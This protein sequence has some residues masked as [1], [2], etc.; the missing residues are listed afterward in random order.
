MA[1]HFTGK[2]NKLAAIANLPS[3]NLLLL[4]SSTILNSK[5]ITSINPVIFIYIQT[6]CSHCQKETESLLKNYSSLKN[7]K[8][9]FLTSMSLYDLKQFDTYYHLSS[10][11]NI[12]VGKDYEHSFAKV[13]M[14]KTVPFMAIYNNNKLVKIYKGDIDVQVILE[15]V[16]I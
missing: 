16:K 14:P 3:F 11:K 4:D 5:Q 10:Y 13:F 12:T 2:E 9:Y 1:C 7:A 8:L 6:D 15:A